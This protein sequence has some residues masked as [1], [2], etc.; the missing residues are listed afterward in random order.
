MVQKEQAI[1]FKVSRQHFRA[2]LGPLPLQTA[3]NC[4]AGFLRR[5]RQCRLASRSRFMAEKPTDYEAGRSKRMITSIII[6][7]SDW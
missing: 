7:C 1:D 4:G 5:V 6:H 2:A 3:R